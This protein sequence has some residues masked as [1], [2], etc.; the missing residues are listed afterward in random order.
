M[1]LNVLHNSRNESWN[2]EE[3]EEKFYILTLTVAAKCFSNRYKEM[4]P[5]LPAITATEK[6]MIG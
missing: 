5:S 1:I 3:R 2:V 4:P 6:S